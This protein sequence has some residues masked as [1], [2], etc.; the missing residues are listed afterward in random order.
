MSELP[1][2]CIR[3]R[4]RK[5][6]CNKRNPCN[7]CT[8]KGLTCQFPQKF[9]NIAIDNPA[10]AKETSSSEATEV[11]LSPGDSTRLEE[12]SRALELDNRKLIETNSRLRERYHSLAPDPE[13]SAI[14]DHM[15]L[16]DH[17]KIS[18]E[19]SEQG[20][21]YYGPLLSH[22]MTE[23]FNNILKHTMA[24]GLPYESFQSHS[25]TSEPF[26]LAPGS[27]DDDSADEGVFTNTKKPLPWV[28]HAKALPQANMQA[29]RYLVDY[30]FEIKTYDYFISRQKV[31]EFL[32][33]YDS[34]SDADWECDDDLV[35][36]FMI[37]ILLIQ[38]LRPSKYNTFSREPAH[39]YEDL[40]HKIRPLKRMLFFHFSQLRHN[41]INESYV[42]VQ[43]YILCTEWEFTEQ[44][45][46][47]AWSMLFHCCSI[48][49]ALGL[50]V[51]MSSD[52]DSDS[53][54]GSSAS[55][56][57]LDNQGSTTDDQ[58]SHDTYF[59]EELP[60]IRVWFALR[61]VCLQMCSI[62]GRPNPIMTS[63]NLV[64]LPNVSMASLE[65]IRLRDSLT[66]SLLKS[67]LSECV[68][69]LNTHV[70]ESYM[71]NISIDNVMTI[72]YRYGEEI[73]NL[74][75][76]LSPQYESLIHDVLKQI[77]SLTDMPTFVTRKD[78]LVDLVV[79]HVNRVK[80]LEPFLDWKLKDPLVLAFIE[81]SILL[82]LDHTC[83]LVLEMVKYDV[84]QV[85]NGNE[86]SG[87]DLGLDKVYFL[88][89]PFLASFIYQGVVVIFIFL[90]YIADDFVHSQNELFLQQ[91]EDR[92]LQLIALHTSIS[93][94]VKDILHGS[95]HLWSGS[96][97]F[98]MRK[99]LEHI[100]VIKQA[101]KNYKASGNIE[102]G[103]Q[104]FD[105]D[106]R[107]AEMLG[108]NL[109]DPFW[110]ANP[111]NAHILG[112]NNSGGMMGMNDS[113][114]GMMSQRSG[115]MA[116]SLPGQDHSNM[117][118]FQE[119][120]VGDSNGHAGLKNEYA[121][122]GDLLFGDAIDMDEDLE[123]IK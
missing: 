122:M 66:N 89:D 11:S 93:D 32:D 119:M 60:K 121:E 116:N 70:I 9:R 120:P 20:E 72:N 101:Y 30:F 84:P 76:Y 14:S 91:V 42:T 17:M 61:N 28:V 40:W 34:L 35:L 90:N 115:D 96:N 113:Y 10:K 100:S 102:P 109:K 92:L 6:K 105:Y 103:F 98:L 85:I 78:V 108:T 13:T 25:W 37:L 112:M 26:R 59:Q 56:S 53:T 33:S 41:L 18:G 73:S 118:L 48:A 24:R 107:V 110:L 79:L 19:T 106:P 1:I 39:N 36:L 97:M 23:D 29:I 83:E 74:T 45:Y 63:V 43:A 68:R 67:G 12:R 52:K 46:E 51:V 86:A 54:K 58:S 104:G 47:E 80:L 22:N 15:K 94:A 69:L 87:T 117:G 57:P 31:D 77:D 50:H 62:M 123:T 16:D 65:D 55:H 49:Y 27:L 4:R 75:Y 81:E 114:S 64:S 5:I 3:C 44:R 21:R 38:R 88:R 8:T 82:F 95:I 7:Q 2:S 111:E 71:R 99:N